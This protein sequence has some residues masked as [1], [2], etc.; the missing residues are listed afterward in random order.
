MKKRIL[1][2][3]GIIV[4]SITLTV[5]GFVRADDVCGC[6]CG[7]PVIVNTT[8]CGCKWTPSGA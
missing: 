2:I 3:A 5:V 1:F 6:G 7:M 4:L 8:H